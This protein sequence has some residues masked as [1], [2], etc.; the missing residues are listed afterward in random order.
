MNEYTSIAARLNAP[1]FP[2][3][4]SMSNSLQHYVQARLADKIT[5]LQQHGGDVEWSENSVIVTGIDQQV[6]DDFDKEILSSLDEFT[7]PSLTSNNWNKLTHVNEDDT[8]F[9]SQ[10]ISDYS[11][12]KIDLDCRNRSVSIM[13]PQVFVLEVRKKIFKEIYQELPLLE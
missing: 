10:L 12:V 2:V 8:S 3:V 1:V 5:E 7:S 4:K 13:G 6:L 9:I 11:E